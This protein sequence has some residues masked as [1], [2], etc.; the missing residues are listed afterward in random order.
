MSFRRME[1]PSR[2]GKVANWFA[3]SP[4]LTCLP[5]FGM[6][7]VVR[8][9]SNLTLQDFHVSHKKGD[10]FDEVGVTY[11]LTRYLDTR[12]LYSS[13]SRDERPI[14]SGAKVS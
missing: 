9:T 5:C 2:K 12:G 3:R 8:G 13:Q 7:Q 11:G 4:F 1:D 6:T 10:R 14:C